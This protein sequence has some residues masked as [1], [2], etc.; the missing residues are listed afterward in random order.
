M[1]NR[2]SIDAAI[3]RTMK[4]RKVLVHQQLVSFKLAFATYLASKLS[5][6]DYP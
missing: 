2:Y 1:N 3:V 4:S 6:T 5:R